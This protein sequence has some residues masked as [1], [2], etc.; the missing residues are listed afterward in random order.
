MGKIYE[1]KRGKQYV[2][3]YRHSHRVKL[4]G[5]RQGKTRGSGPSKVITQNIYLGTP[6]KIVQQI[7]GFSPD[8]R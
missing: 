7:K 2:Y 5:E 3:Y 8:S 4:D 1:V 6:E